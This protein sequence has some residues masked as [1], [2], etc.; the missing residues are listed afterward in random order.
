M[1]IFSFG[2]R[3]FDKS[4]DLVNP[5]PNFAFRI[6]RGSLQ[7]RIID[8]RQHTV[9]ARHPAVAKN[10]PIFFVL[11]RLRFRLEGGE[12]LLNGLVQGRCREVLQF[13]DGVH[14]AV[15]SSRFSVVPKAERDVASNVSAAFSW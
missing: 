3:V 10:F 15:I 13:G 1:N 4:S 8:L 12:Q 2:D 6:L 9:L 11:D 7:P 5:L 14:G